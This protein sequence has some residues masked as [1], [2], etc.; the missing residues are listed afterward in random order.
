MNGSTWISPVS[1]F[2]S[3]T[4]TPPA[5]AAR[6]YRSSVGMGFTLRCC[7][8]HG[9]GNGLRQ[10]GRIERLGQHWRIEG[11]SQ[12]LRQPIAVTCDEN[13]GWT[14]VPTAYA[15]AQVETAQARQ[16]YIGDDAIQGQLLG[17]E[18]LRRCDAP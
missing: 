1:R 13:H 3:H 10:H 4:P 7:R 2:Q 8:R 6:L 12:V 14:V 18:I 9:R 16:S 17:F 11:V 5:I 15:L